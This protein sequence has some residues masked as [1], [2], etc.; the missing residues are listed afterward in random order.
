MRSER[1]MRAMTGKVKRKENKRMNRKLMMMAG[2]A[3]LLCAG[4]VFANDGPEVVRDGAVLG[5][6]QFNDSTFK[7][8]SSVWGNDITAD[9]PNGM[10]GV[11]GG[12]AAFG[13]DGS[14]YLNIVGKPKTVSVS[15]AKAPAF[16]NTTAPYFTLVE[17]FKSSKAYATSSKT[18]TDDCLNDTTRWHFLAARYQ[19]GGASKPTYS[20]YSYMF[21]CDPDLLWNGTDFWKAD[22]RPEDSANSV[23]KIPLSV[24]GTTVAIG[25]YVGTT[26]YSYEGA[27]D[28]VIVIN[29][30]LTKS[31]ITRCFLTGET[32]VY[33]NGTPSFVSASGWSSNEGSINFKPGDIPRQ[34]YIVDG[35]KTITQGATATFGGDGFTGSLTLGRL[36]PLMNRVA[37]PNSVIV[38]ASAGNLVQNSVNTTITIG[39]LRLRKGRVTSSSDGQTLVATKLEVVAPLECP[40]EINVSSGMYTVAGAASGDGWLKKTGAGTLDLT[41]LTGAAKVVVTEGKVLAGP[42]VTVTYDLEEDRGAVPVLMAE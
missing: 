27:L 9:F 5:Y 22:E 35:G 11:A 16:N 26:S 2:G 1:G 39:D 20:S 32:Y 23:A 25:G 28:D 31:E 19:V 12:T 13:Y 21:C 14:G 4:M 7:K 24:S 6:W 10:S 8:D 38:E 34:A 41:G 40:Y 37:N 3:G 36:E 15:I 42:N 18:T 29:R 30:M 17:R 33:P